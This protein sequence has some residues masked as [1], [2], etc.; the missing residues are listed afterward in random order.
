MASSINTATWRQP[1]VN[2]P[3][4]DNQSVC[5]GSAGMHNTATVGGSA[6]KWGLGVFCG[7]VGNDLHYEAWGH[8][9][10]LPERLVVV[11]VMC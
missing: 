8:F 5:R 9:T 7:I 2:K 1:G 4:T 10:R 3:W 6:S 11:V